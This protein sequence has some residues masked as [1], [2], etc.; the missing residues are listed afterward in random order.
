MTDQ[1]QNDVLTEVS[2]KSVVVTVIQSTREHKLKVLEKT[3]YNRV[4]YQLFIE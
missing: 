2:M 4:K 3:T 1:L